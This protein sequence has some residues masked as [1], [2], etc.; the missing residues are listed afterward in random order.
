MSEPTYTITLTETERTAFAKVLGGFV[1]KL[2]NA[3]VQIDS[4]TPATSA[5]SATN[6]TSAPVPST[7]QPSGHVP[8]SPIEARDRWARDRKGNEAPNPKGCTMARLVL[9]NTEQKK[10]KTGDYLKVTFTAPHEGHTDA[11]CFDSQ[12]FPWLIKRAH[13][14]KGDLTTVFLV[15]SGKYLNIVGVR[16]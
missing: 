2:L 9:W 12:L 5:P 3:P 4:A 11:S 8:P 14:S 1:T 16:A 13:E 7:A 10:G 15:E 6:A